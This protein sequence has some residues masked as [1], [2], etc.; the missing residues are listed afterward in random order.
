MYADAL[1]FSRP[2]SEPLERGPGPESG[3]AAAPVPSRA[4][5]AGNGTYADDPLMDLA[6]DVLDRGRLSLRIARVLQAVSRQTDSAVVAL[7]GPW[8][9]GKTTLLHAVHRDLLEQ[10]GW[11]LARYNPWSYSTLDSAVVG[12]FAE[13]RAA[14]P[15]DA[16]GTDRGVP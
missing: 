8:G 2:G 1:P 7:V 3:G 11:Y 9:S 5:A 10:G 12:F 15:E 16:L 6:T 4:G 14:L 13:L